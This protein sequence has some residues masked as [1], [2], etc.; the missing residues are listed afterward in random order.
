[1]ARRG[2]KK[3]EPLSPARQPEKPTRVVPELEAFQSAYGDE[4]NRIIVNPAFQSA[5][6]VLNVSKLKFISGLQDGEIAQ[7]GATILADLRGHLQ[8][9]NDLTTLHTKKDFT[10]PYEEPEEYFAPEMVAQLEQ[11][12]EQFREQMRRQHYNA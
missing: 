2:K 9:E 4:W 1:M 3:V 10:L 7:H 6:L 12:K 8:L 11:K 5:L